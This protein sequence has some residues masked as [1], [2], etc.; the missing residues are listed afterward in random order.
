MQKNTKA[1]I[2]VASALLLASSFAGAKSRHSGIK[3]V[4]PLVGSIC[5]SKE[6]YYKYN[7]LSLFKKN[8]ED[9]ISTYCTKDNDRIIFI[10]KDS[11]IV[12][13]NYDPN[14]LVR[15]SWRPFSLEKETKELGN[16]KSSHCLD[17]KDPMEIWLLTEKGNV[18]IIYNQKEPT[19]TIMQRSIPWENI[20][21]KITNIKHLNECNVLLEGC[22]NKDT[23]ECNKFTVTNT[24]SGCK[25]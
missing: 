25:K 18:I 14:S 13:Y 10:F 20:G 15:A 8:A 1:A 19:D 23:D 6:D 16:I 2:A 22:T 3:G 5:G 4:E 17:D 7:F 9:L 24:K 21:F 12:L 11:I